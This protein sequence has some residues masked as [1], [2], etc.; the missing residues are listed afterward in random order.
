ML[1]TKKPLVVLGIDPG[2][3]DTGF[4][5]VSFSGQKMEAITYGSI[6]T[7]A[8]QPMAKRLTILAS[9]L[10]KIIAHHRPDMVGI[11]QL[12]FAKNAKTAMAV[13]QARGVAMLVVAQAN[14]PIR[15]L[16]P[17]QVKSA[18][19]GYGKA[20]KLQIQQMVKTLLQLDSI[21]KPDDA[22]D[23]LAVAICVGR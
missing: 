17:L 9:D 6:K 22:A 21:P 18:L 5:I 16:T 10:R 20:T 2:L 15:E 3:A 12:F 4:G 13:G 1:K 14:L 11:E 19:V 7:A 8:G 23:A